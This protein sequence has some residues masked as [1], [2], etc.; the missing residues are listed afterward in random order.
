[1]LI[2]ILYID[3]ITILGDNPKCITYIKFT[4]SNRY[5]ITDLGEIDSYLG[6][7]IKCDKSS[8]QL[9]IDQF[10]YA[11]E[12]VNHF[13]LSDTYTVCTP[14]PNGANVHLKKYDG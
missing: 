13:G 10:H 1:M 8:K 3:D 11:L 5:K 2:I 4:L 14:L 6:V 9:E 7:W 12:I